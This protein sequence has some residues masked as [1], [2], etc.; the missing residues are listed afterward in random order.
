MNRWIELP[1]QITPPIWRSV[2]ARLQAD[3]R[4]FLAGAG[5][6]FRMSGN[7]VTIAADPST[8]LYSR[9]LQRADGAI[10]TDAARTLAK[11]TVN[12]SFTKPLQLFSSGTG[13]DR[14]QMDW[15]T[16][17][18]LDFL[19]EPDPL[20]AVRDFAARASGH[21]KIRVGGQL[22]PALRT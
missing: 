10:R 17:V 6:R 8:F 14:E 19:G 11:D 4:S 7:R 22:G 12:V 1:P 15:W 9:P 3:M 5:I 2:Q 16:K 13:F 20:K 21:G 18:R